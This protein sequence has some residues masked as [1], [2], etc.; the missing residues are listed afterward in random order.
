MSAL[1]RFSH[2]QILSLRFFKAE[3][4]FPDFVD[5]E[6]IDTRSFARQLIKAIEDNASV[7]YLE[8]LISESKKAINRQARWCMENLVEKD[9]SPEWWTKYQDEGI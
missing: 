6:P 7:N 8:C 5:S 4:A 9:D 2:N 3:D 1:I